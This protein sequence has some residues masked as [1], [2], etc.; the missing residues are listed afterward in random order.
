MLVPGWP[1]GLS[2]FSGVEKL[3][4]DE[5]GLHRLSAL[6]RY[7][8]VS[9]GD[10]LHRRSRSRGPFGGQ[11]RTGLASTVVPV[12]IGV[13]LAFVWNIMAGSHGPEMPQ[14]DPGPAPTVGTAVDQ[15]ADQAWASVTPTSTRIPDRRPSPPAGS[16]GPVSTDCARARSPRVVRAAPAVDSAHASACPSLRRSP[17]ARKKASAMSASTTGWSA[18]RSVRLLRHADR[19]GVEQGEPALSVCR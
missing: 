6:V 4:S 19:S 3:P 2:G 7:V 9:R 17:E 15:A 12:M 1:G 5:T 13:I 8:S 18:H 11:G 14:G 10:A 16:R